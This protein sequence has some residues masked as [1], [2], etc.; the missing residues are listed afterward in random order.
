MTIGSRLSALGATLFACA[1]TAPFDSQGQSV[2][3]QGPFD[4]RLPSALAQGRAG[5]APQMAEAVF[6]NVQ[7][8]K[9]I[10]V[11]EFMDAMGMFSAALGYDCSSCH[12]KDISSNREAFA[13]ATPLIQRAR[14][15]IAM[16]SN[17]NRMYFGGQPRVTCFTCHRGNYRPDAVPN[18]ALQYGA[19]IEDPNAME[20][21]P[22]REGTVDQLFDKYV[23]AVGGP[24]RVAALTSF[25]ATGTYA[26]FNTGGGD[27][28][29]EIF[30]RAPNQRATVVRMPDGEAVKT[31]D[32]RSAWAA[33]G[34]RP[35]PLLPLTGGNLLGARIDAIAQFP[36]AIRPAFAQWRLS[37]TII[38]DNPVDILQG[39]NP[40]E[41]PVNFYFDESGL[42]IRMVRWNRTAVGPVPTQVDYSDYKE[43]AGVKLPFHIVVTWTDGQNTTTLKDVRPN[44]SIDP[45]RFTRPAPFQRRAIRN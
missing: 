24:Q 37:S 43:V 20:I 10:P 14:G 27:V 35:L 41:L 30:A 29:I 22:S 18:L 5:D 3:A 25:T 21:I 2:L 15:M 23:K 17:L 8:L 36:S 38:D 44:V 13:V 19:L 33:E 12:S 16:T 40:G 28:P 39:A 42:L 34:W 31:Y 6:K 1:L 4:S 45:G 26:G 9:G 32:G 7:M 11:D